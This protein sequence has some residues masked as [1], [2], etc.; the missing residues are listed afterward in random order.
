MKTVYH[1]C[2]L[3]WIFSP[4]FWYSFFP[5]LSDGFCYNCSVCDFQLLFVSGCTA[6]HTAWNKALPAPMLPPAHPW[7]VTGP[8]LSPISF[9]HAIFPSVWPIIHSPDKRP[10]SVLRMQVRSY[11]FPLSS[12]QWFPFSLRMKSRLLHV[13]G[14]AWLTSF[15][16]TALTAQ[17]PVFPLFL[18]F[19]CLRT[20]SPCLPCGLCIDCSLCRESLT[21]HFKCCLLA[22]PALKWNFHVPSLLRKVLSG[23]YQ[24]LPEPIFSG[25]LLFF[26]W[27]SLC[28]I[29]FHCFFHI[30]YFHPLNFKY[31]KKE[32]R[33]WFS[34]LSL[35][36][37]TID[38]PMSSWSNAVQVISKFVIVGVSGLFSPG[39]CILVHNAILSSNS[40]S[41]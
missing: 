33:F 6:Q 17:P 27:L 19:L 34:P 1:I 4:W 29:T 20:P 31:H 3:L 12:F 7:A 38:C 16:S 13:A 5:F 24:M 2:P 36:S 25:L 39:I 8:T 9:P 10:G 37:S 22:A 14:R 40:F 41:T 28:K 21:L 18:L 26:L 30:I 15:L 23:L 35:A 11:H 32:Y